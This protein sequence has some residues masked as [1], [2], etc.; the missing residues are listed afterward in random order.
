[1]KHASMQ[2][3][4]TRYSSVYTRRELGY[5]PDM[6]PLVEDLALPAYSKRLFKLWALSLSMQHLLA[7][8]KALS[9]TGME[10]DDPWGVSR[11]VWP[12][13]VSMVGDIPEL[14]DLGCVRKGERP[15][16]TC[17]VSIAVLNARGNNLE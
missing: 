8:M 14:L 9:K 15:C 17:L 7:P 16:D 11:M 10:I 3:Y 2:H 13:L 5:F 6:E 1:M 12:F 4:S